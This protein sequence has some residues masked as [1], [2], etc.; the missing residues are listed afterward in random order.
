MTVLHLAAMFGC[1]FVLAFVFLFLC[2][3]LAAE[4]RYD[5]DNRLIAAEFVCQQAL[6]MLHA[7]SPKDFAEAQRK[8]YA[9]AKQWDRAEYL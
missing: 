9:G 1:A 8:L 4:R 3:W 5:L 7:E 2:V 6:E